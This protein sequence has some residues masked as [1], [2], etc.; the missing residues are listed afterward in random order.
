M[1]IGKGLKTKMEDILIRDYLV[2]K[3]H[4]I[5]LACVRIMCQNLFDVSTVCSDVDNNDKVW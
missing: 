5:Y 3:H 2:K 4:I 1:L